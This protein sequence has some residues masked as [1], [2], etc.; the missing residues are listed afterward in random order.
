MAKW[1]SFPC[2]VHF[3]QLIVELCL[4]GKDEGGKRVFL[5]LL[6]AVEGFPGG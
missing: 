5:G 6:V 2:F 3:F 1:C 4:D